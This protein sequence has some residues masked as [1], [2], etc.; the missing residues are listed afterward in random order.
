MVILVFSNNNDVKKTYKKVPL[1]APTREAGWSEARG[2]SYMTAEQALK[3]IW[4][5][6]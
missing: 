5:P 3:R 4:L 6:S 1:W 2:G